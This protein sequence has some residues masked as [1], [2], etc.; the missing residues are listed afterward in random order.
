MTR[1]EFMANLPHI[2]NAMDQPSIDGINTWYASKA[3]AELGLKV[4]VSGVR[5]DE[6]FFGYESFRQL[7]RLVTAWR[8]LYR[9][10]CAMPMA[11]LAA[12]LQSRCSGNRR[13][14]YAPEWAQSIAGTWW[15]RRSSQAP[16]EAAAMSIA[17]SEALANFSVADW[18]SE[19]SGP[20]AEDNTLALAQIESTTYLRNQLLRDSDWASMYHS[21]ELRTPLV[22]AHLL[23]GLQ[24]N[25]GSFRHFPG[26]KLLAYAPSKPLPEVIIN[27]RKSG[28]FIPVKRW[29]QEAYGKEHNWQETVARLWEESWR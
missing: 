29:L 21:V 11:K 27:R 6:L 13:W 24:P 9:L 1:E 25:L 4:V 15:L 7:P 18:I 12:H 22:D 14:L 28:F 3:T 8:M 23:N 19:M 26:K 20:L 10:P 16:G 17:I 5:G 2:M